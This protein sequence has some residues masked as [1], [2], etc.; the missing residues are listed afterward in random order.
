M[1]KQKNFFI[2]SLFLLTSFNVFSMVTDNRFFPW[3]PYQFLAVDDRPSHV[4]GELFFTTASQAFG[5][6]EE[7]VG[8]PELYVSLIKEN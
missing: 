5:E 3:L 4:A 7:D 6:N 8:I 1:I 2:V